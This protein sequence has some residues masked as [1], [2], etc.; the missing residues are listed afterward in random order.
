[1]YYK[2]EL[3]NQAEVLV[4][5]NTS[6]DALKAENEALVNQVDGLLDSQK[7]EWAE[8]RQKDKDASFQDGVKIYDSRFLVVDP[9]YNFSKFG[10]GTVKLIETFKI[11][12]QGDIRAKRIALG[13]EEATVSEE[14]ASILGIPIPVDVSLIQVNDDV[15]NHPPPQKDVPVEPTKDAPDSLFKDA[16]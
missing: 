3:V 16:P 15:E 13:I 9:E 12:N 6:Y 1:M 8:E 5:L 14:D 11:T 7:N 2:Q 4:G 10:E